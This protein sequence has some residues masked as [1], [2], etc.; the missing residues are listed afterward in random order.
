ML[1]SLKVPI[2]ENCWL[3]VAAMVELPG[4]IASE[5]KSAAFTVAVALPLTEPD[6]AVIV[7]VPRLRAVT[8]PLTVIEAM[9]VF[10]ELHVTVPVMSCVVPS[11]NV[12]VAVNCCNVPSGIDGDAGVTAIEFAVAFVTVRVALEK[13]LPELAVIAELPAAMPIARPGALFTLMPATAR[14]PE[15]HC[16]APV[17]FCVLPSLKVP[18]AVNCVVVPCA[19]DVVKGVIAIDCTVALVVVTLALDEMLPEAAVIVE[20]PS[21]IAI[22]SPNVEFALIATAEGLAD[23]HCTEAVISLVLP[24][25]KVPVAASCAV[26]PIG[27][28]VL[29]GE[30]IRAASAA[31]VTVR[32]VLPLT[33]E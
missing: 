9:L 4:R 16:T 32:L 30:T 28:D 6:A 17:M 2:A 33:P 22:A 31:A 20:V 24:S 10:E 15:L 26:V 8:R 25:V 29:A 21:A 5:A 11:E 12:P 1:P 19:I 18:M 23:V 14:F 3:V 7:A 13:T 27:N